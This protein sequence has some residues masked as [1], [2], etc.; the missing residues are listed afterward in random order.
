MNANI[1]PDGEI[2]VH[3]L[4]YSKADLDKVPAEERLFFLMAGSVANDTAI[5]NKLLLAS[6]KNQ[7]DFGS[8]IAGQG[9]STAAVFILRMLS[10]R[11][12]EAGKLTAKSSNLIK[13]RYEADLSQM[14][15]DSFY[16]I[17]RYFAGKRSLLLN[18]RD[19]MAFHHL[20]ESVERAYLTLDESIDLGDYMQTATGNTL[21][22]TAELLHYENLKNLSGL[23]HEEAIPRWVDDAT[24]QSKNFGNFVNGYALV[25]AKRYLPQAFDKLAI[26]AEQVP[27]IDLQKIVLP[28]FTVLPDR[29]ESVIE[30]CCR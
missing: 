11:L 3:S 28:F 5:L 24:E 20:S 26:E 13:T 10:G 27:A 2:T 14:A 16:A 17:L 4:V 23:P 29:S 12:V 22:Y 1:L 8:A 21:Y 19:Q 6:V 30:T 25:F 18:I 15:K 7:S 9:N